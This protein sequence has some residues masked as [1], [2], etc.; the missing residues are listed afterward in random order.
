MDTTFAV[1]KRKP[2]KIQARMGFETLDFCHTGAHS[3]KWANKPT[4]RRSLNKDDYEV[5]NIW[6]SYMRS[7]GWRIIDTTFATAKRKPHSK[8]ILLVLH[9][10]NTLI[11][12]IH[13]AIFWHNIH[14]LNCCHFL[15]FI[16]LSASS[17]TGT[18][19]FPKTEDFYGVFVSAIDSPGH[20]WVQ[21]ITKDSPDLDK[22]TNE[23]TQLY[24]SSETHAVI[25]A[26]KVCML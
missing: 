10:Y 19:Q 3:T 25:N 5:M 6:K 9:V 4:G 13:S 8:F 11:R 26:F 22:L 23:L 12:P 1:A 2:E 21:I 17:T 15:N 24:S 18:V 16:I 7:V 14:L 20:F